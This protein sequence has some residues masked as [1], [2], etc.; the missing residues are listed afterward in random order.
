MRLKIAIG[1][2]M[3]ATLA[4]CTGT[5]GATGGD[6]GKLSVIVAEPVS[7]ATV[8]IPFTV[9]V[10][11]SVPLGSS[12]SGQHHVHIWFDDNETDYLIV[13]SNTTQITDAPSGQHTMHV[14]LRNANH[15]PAGAEATTPIT[16]GSGGVHVPSPSAAGEGT[17]PTTSDPYTY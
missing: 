5:N 15:S 3:L 14:S 10:D 17:S 9:K 16:I 13:E 4:A 8:S 7:G 11:S 1:A 2:A 6:S 12:E